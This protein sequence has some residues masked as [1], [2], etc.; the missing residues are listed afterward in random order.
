[1]KNISLFLKSNRCLD[2][3]GI[4]FFIA[5]LTFLIYVCVDL[6][7]RKTLRNKKLIKAGTCVISSLPCVAFALYL[8]A[9]NQI[10]SMIATLVVALLLLGI[11]SICL[12]ISTEG[13]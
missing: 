1:M 11:S 5:L 6:A 9:T 8:F 13:R 10:I 2:L 3:I 4:I 12:S 7:L